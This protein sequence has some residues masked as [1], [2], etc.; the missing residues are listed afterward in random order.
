MSASIEVTAPIAEGTIVVLRNVQIED[1]ETWESIVEQMGHVA[2]H[3]R[4]LVLAWQDDGEVELWGPDTDLRGRVSALL[5]EA[6][7]PAPPRRPG[8]TGAAGWQ[9]PRSRPAPPPSRP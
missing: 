4:F 2:G 9:G 5:A 8:E 1:A 7:R 6:R 3:D